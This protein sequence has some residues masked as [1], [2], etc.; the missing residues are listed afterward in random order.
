MAS[1]SAIGPAIEELV[2]EA[3]ERFGTIL[4]GDSD[5]EHEPPSASLDRRGE[6]ARRL[7]ET[8]QRSTVREDR[9]APALPAARRR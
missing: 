9:A 4:A 2:A 8:R 5:D 6:D 7:V 1:S 3:A